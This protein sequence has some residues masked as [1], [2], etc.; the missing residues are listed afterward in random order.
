[1]R[2]PSRLRVLHHAALQ[3]TGRNAQGGAACGSSAG[4]SLSQGCRAAIQCMR[5]GASRD[6]EGGGNSQNGPCLSAKACH[7]ESEAPAEPH[8][9]AEAS[10]RAV[11][12]LESPS[13]V[14][15][16]LQIS[17]AEFPERA[18][19]VPGGV[20]I[21][22]LSLRGSRAGSGVPCRRSAENL[23]G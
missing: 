6:R 4:A 22:R 1:M 13:Y 8:R 16:G 7:R 19:L 20:R 2:F 21:R 18:G 17:R 9:R 5:E 11:L 15:R 23:R 14:E 12:G 10:L 3:N